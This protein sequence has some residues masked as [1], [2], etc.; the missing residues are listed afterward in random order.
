MVRPSRADPA[1][2]AAI[3][4]RQGD[5][6]G[7]YLHVG[8]A[9]GVA[10]TADGVDTFAGGAVSLTRLREGDL[11]GAIGGRIVAAR[12]TERDAGRIDAELVL[13]TRR[14][15]L[16]AG[17]SGGPIAAL[18]DLQHPRIGGAV[19]I[20]CYLG[21]VPYVRMGVIAASGRFIEAGLELPLP[22]WRW[23]R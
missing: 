1:P 19:R 5:L 21:V 3:V 15:G 9:L 14:L 20:W 12:W 2:T 4:H 22:V 18:D 7:L 6:D 23:R 10:H 17:I 13:G 16:L 8:P 11:L